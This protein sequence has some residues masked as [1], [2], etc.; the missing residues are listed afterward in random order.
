MGGAVWFGYVQVFTK[1]LERLPTKVCEG[2]VERDVAIQTLPRTRTAEESSERR[3]QGEDFEFHCRIYTS[4][5][6]ILTGAAR[7]RDAYTQSWLRHYGVNEGSEVIR[8]STNGVQALAALDDSHGTSSVYLACVPGGV[9][10]EDATESYAIVTEASI[11]GEG[12]VSG[13]ALRQ[14]VTDFAYQLTQHA[15][16]LAECQAP[17]DL[18]ED[19]PRYKAAVE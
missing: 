5:G 7:V 1:G 14:A 16:E 15:Y 2:A 12:R 8:V 10:A 17:R 19:L 18:P 13:A 6:S 4:T 3:G 11:V 9:Q